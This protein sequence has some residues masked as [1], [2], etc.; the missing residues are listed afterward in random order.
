M[1]H[2]YPMRAGA[3]ASAPY[4]TNL[5]HPNGAPVLMEWI[6]MARFD[7][8][9]DGEGD[10]G[11]QK[12]TV[13]RQVPTA[14]GLVQVEETIDSLHK[15]RQI[16]RE[17]E[18]RFRDGEGEKLAFRAYSQDPTNTDVGLFGP[19]TPESARLTKSGRVS[20]KAITPAD[21]SEPTVEVGPG[22]SGSQALAED[23]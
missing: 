9:T 16:E 15:L 22:M 5:D 21:G 14:D 2:E 11:F 4:C 19:F 13:H 6:P 23:K 12:F 20:V 7:L 18:Q 8:K 3:V 10:Q 17:S 1:E